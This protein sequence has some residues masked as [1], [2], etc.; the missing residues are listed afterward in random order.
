MLPARH[1]VSLHRLGKENM[2][3]PKQIATVMEISQVIYYKTATMHSLLSLPPQKVAAEMRATEICQEEI[4]PF[5]DCTLA[6]V[7]KSQ[8]D[9]G[10]AAG[11]YSSQR[12]RG[13]SLVFAASIP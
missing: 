5:R 2:G 10:D 9:S 11:A 7:V 3:P 12:A 1:L 6:H 13:H 4:L 8:R